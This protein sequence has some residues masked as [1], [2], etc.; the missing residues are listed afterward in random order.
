MNVKKIHKFSD[1]FAYCVQS[2]LTMGK[3]EQING[4]VAMALDKLAGI[5]SD[6]VRTDPAWEE[7]D[8]VKLTEALQLWVCRN[9]I[10]DAA[11]MKCPR[12]RD[13]KLLHAKLSMR[14]CVYCEGKEHKSSDCSKVANIKERKQT[15]ANATSVFQLYRVRT[16]SG[17]LYKQAVMSELPTTPPYISLR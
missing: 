5:G 9:P 10:H 4:N 16:S 12:N 6:L 1:K 13:S 7:W 14:G 15:F 17:E 3:L 2:L 8:Y 11:K